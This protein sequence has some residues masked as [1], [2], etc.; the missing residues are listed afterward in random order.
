MEP[1]SSN[2]T[3]RNTLLRTYSFVII[4]MII[5]WNI[6]PSSTP[7]VQ[8]IDTQVDVQK[9]ECSCKLIVDDPAKGLYPLYEPVKVR[10]DG[11]ESAG[12]M[13]CE[14]KVSKFEL[15]GFNIVS[16]KLECNE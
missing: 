3:T 4:C 9:I 12:L 11:T 10:M 6:W 1:N 15:K 13:S 8:T 2:E 7:A 14:K 5:L 16:F